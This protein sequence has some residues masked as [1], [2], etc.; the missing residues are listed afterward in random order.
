MSRG[1]W[2]GLG[3][4]P[5]GPEGIFFDVKESFAGS[6]VDS[7]LSGSL[8]EQLGF[9]KQKDGKRVGEIAQE[10]VLKEAVIAIP[11]MERKNKDQ[12]EACLT[13]IDSR[14]FFKIDSKIMK[15]QLQEGADTTITRM[16]DKLQQYV[17]PPNYNFLRYKNIDPFVMYIFEF[18]TTFSQQDLAYIWQGVMPDASL[19]P[20]HE[21]VIIKHKT[22]E[23]EFF[24]GKELPTD[25]RWMMFKVKQRAKKSYSDVINM[26]NKDEQ[27]YGYN[28]P[29]DYC[30]LVELAKLDVDIKITPKKDTLDANI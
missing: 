17:I 8:I 9:K 27:E 4:L 24:H 26:T 25:I 23:N 28:W 18:D 15:K 19:S 1:M 3:E 12:N 22:G 6:S 2:G 20:V 10:T 21:E 29:Y 30:S 14:N 16:V 5:T 13:T 7:S 11:F